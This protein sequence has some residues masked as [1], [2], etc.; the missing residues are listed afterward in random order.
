LPQ[1]TQNVAAKALQDFDAE[2]TQADADKNGKLDYKE[3][4]T[5]KLPGTTPEGVRREAFRQLASLDGDPQTLTREELK[6]SLEPASHPVRVIDMQELLGFRLMST[7]AEAAEKT[8]ALFIKAGGKPSELFADKPNLYS[9]A[10]ATVVRIFGQNLKMTPGDPKLDEALSSNP[11]WNSE[12]TRLRDLYFKELGEKLGKASPELVRSM[13]DIAYKA[14]DYEALS[15][16]DFALARFCSGRDDLKEIMLHE[17][18]KKID[19]IRPPGSPPPVL[20]QVVYYLHALN[21]IDGRKGEAIVLAARQANIPIADAGFAHGET[22][23][24]SRS[25]RIEELKKTGMSEERAKEELMFDQQWKKTASE[26]TGRYAVESTHIMRTATADQIFEMHKR[27]SSNSPVNGDA[28]MRDTVE[29]SRMPLERVQQLM[30][31]GRE[32]EFRPNVNSA[33]AGDRLM[34]ILAEYATR[35][36]R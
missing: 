27:L 16:L 34:N 28:L 29:V 14:K 5:I 11:L 22:F 9:E 4:S 24:A 36:S 20:G 10:K 2:F 26:M 21:E 18:P 8:M 3:F 12:V 30:A 13:V 1:T 31:R 33:V 6:G 25:A 15:S 19:A 23:G 17:I 7:Q 32:L 35:L